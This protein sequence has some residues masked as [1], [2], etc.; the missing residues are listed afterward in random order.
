[1]KPARVTIIGGGVVGTNAAKMAVGLGAAV[2]VLDVNTARLEYLDDIFQGRCMTLFS[3]AKNI[4]ESVRE[5]DLVVG[6]VLITGH[7]APTLVTKEMI[8]SMSKGSCSC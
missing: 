7:K 3:N 5:S 1:M 4:E 6:G 8:T 2:T